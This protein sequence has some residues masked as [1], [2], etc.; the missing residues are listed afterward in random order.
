MRR[1][2]LVPFATLVLI[3][4]LIGGKENAKAQRP[5]KDPDIHF[6]QFRYRPQPNSS[7]PIILPRTNTPIR[8]EISI[9][10]IRGQNPP[11]SPV[12]V[13]PILLR[14]LVVQDS[15][16]GEIGIYQFRDSSD[17]GFCGDTQQYRG[18]DCAF[19]RTELPMDGPAFAL[20]AILIIYRDTNQ[21]VLNTD[22]NGTAVSTPLN[23]CVNMWY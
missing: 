20:S 10:Q 21:I 9:S 3:T 19:S 22:N 5:S 16:S 11:S 4:L 7:I 18:I 23:V 2:T 6:Q 14:G 8:I 1:I 17:R 12:P 13:P 15:G